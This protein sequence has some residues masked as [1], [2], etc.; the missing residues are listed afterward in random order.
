MKSLNQCFV[1]GSSF[2]NDRKKEKEKKKEKRR[3]EKKSSLEAE[4]LHKLTFE[5]TK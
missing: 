1:L 5:F 2:V 4:N 3:E